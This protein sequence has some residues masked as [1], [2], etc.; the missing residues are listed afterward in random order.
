VEARTKKTLLL[1]VTLPTVVFL[2]WLAWDRLIQPSL[3]LRITKKEA[4]KVKEG[5]KAGLTKAEDVAIN[6]AM[7]TAGEGELFESIKKG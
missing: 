3:K 1:A 4:K 2:G 5:E 6:P 7:A